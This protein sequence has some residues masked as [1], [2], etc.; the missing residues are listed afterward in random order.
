MV[1][2]LLCRLICC[3]VS[4][5][6]LLVPFNS[7]T[8]TRRPLPSGIK[9]VLETTVVSKRYCSEFPFLHLYL[10][11]RFTNLSDRPILLDSRSK[12]IGRIM[13]SQNPK[14]IVERK[15]LSDVSSDLDFTPF[16]YDPPK[17]LNLFSVLKPGQSYS[18][19][20]RVELLVRDRDEGRLP[21]KYFLQLKVITWH[22]HPDSIDQLRVQWRETGFLWTNDV[23]SEP[24]TFEVERKP[25]SQRCISPKQRI[26]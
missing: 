16:G 9:L 15:Y 2:S 12:L 19:E 11:L 18:T 4:Y 3:L 14:D 24:M 23:T 20:S 21:G 10:S 13:V 8:E 22:Y 6:V 25:P 1:K 7:Q 17:D 26:E 5:G